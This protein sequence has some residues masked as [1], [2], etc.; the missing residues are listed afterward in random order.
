MDESKT[1]D[2]LLD[3]MYGNREALVEALHFFNGEANTR[4]LRKRGDIPRGSMHDLIKLLERWDII[5]QVGK[6]PVGR[7]GRADV[8][9]F[10]DLGHAIREAVISDDSMTNDEMKDLSEQVENL[11]ET[12][13]SISEKID[14]HNG[15]VE[16]H[17]ERIDKLDEEIEGPLKTVEKFIREQQEKD[18]S[19]QS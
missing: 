19:T 15:I 3:E 16:E 18:T 10:T 1:Y 2:D 14:T 12:I 17:G 13:E 5:K 8:F 11:S 9:Q 7:G 4:E 6:E